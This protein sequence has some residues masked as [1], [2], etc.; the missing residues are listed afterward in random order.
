MFD[1]MMT[2]I[3]VSFL[4]VLGLSFTIESGPLGPLLFS[5]SCVG[6]VASVIAWVWGR[7]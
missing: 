1:S 5:F 6:I 3:G 2:L 7:A 4:G